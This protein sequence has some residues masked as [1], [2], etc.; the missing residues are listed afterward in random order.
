MRG[1]SV[2]LSK[3]GC[4]E[5]TFSF[6]I[7]KV[8]L[9]P[10]NSLTHADGEMVSAGSKSVSFLTIYPFLTCLPGEGAIIRVQL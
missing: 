3:R 2:Y 7:T 4:D 9:L 8:N 10:L 1:S 6:V 5:I